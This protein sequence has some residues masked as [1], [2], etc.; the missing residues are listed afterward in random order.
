ME[1]N[2]CLQAATCL[3]SVESSFTHK[4]ASIGQDLR[5]GLKRS[6]TELICGGESERACCGTAARQDCLF[7][8]Q[9]D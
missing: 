7:P 4:L 8:C 5:L 2:N 9:C 6:G 3:Q 1:K